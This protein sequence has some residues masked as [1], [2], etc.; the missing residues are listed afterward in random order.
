MMEMNQRL[1]SPNIES[2]RFFRSAT[3]SG[4]CVA[5]QA[6]LLRCT[7]DVRYEHNRGHYEVISLEANCH[8]L[9]SESVMSQIMIENLRVSDTQFQSE[10]PTHSLSQSLRHTVSVTSRGP[11]PIKQGTPHPQ[12][13]P[14][15]EH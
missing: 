14:P 2:D 5:P 15:A 3:A 7:S 12:G 1:G 13:V 8:S 10:S 4:G 9:S 11:T 6:P